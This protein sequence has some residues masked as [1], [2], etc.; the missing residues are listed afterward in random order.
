VRIVQVNLAWDA[1]LREP[2]ALLA[3]YRTLTG[4]SDALTAAGAR[5]H[6]IQRFS[7]DAR[8]IRGNAV[9]DFVRDGP[10]GTPGPW[11]SLTRVVNAVG[12]RAPDVVHINGLMFP[13]AVR[14]IRERVGRACAVVLQ[15]HSGF[16][17]RTSWWPFG[18]G[19]RS[20]WR[21]AFGDADAC[22]FT[23][24]DLAAPWYAVGLAEDTPIVEIPEAST[25]FVA[26]DRRQ[27]RSWTGLQ[28]DPSILW[29]GRL[30]DNKDPLTVLNALE[31][32]LPVLPAAQ[33]LMIVPADADNPLAHRRHEIAS[34]IASSEAL[35]G[36]ISMIGPLAH[37]E[38]P[39]YYSAAD[40]FVSGSRHEGS[41]YSLIEAMACGVS[42]CVTDVPAFRGLTGGCGALWRAGD[43]AACAAALRDLAMRDLEAERQVVREHFERAMSW[44]V[45]GRRT[46]DTYSTLVS[47]RRAA[48]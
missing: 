27:A 17:P 28:G 41:G 40:I 3:S 8:V 29:V 38:M 5:V 36:R 44:H 34:R 33:V 13:G 37:E 32:V 30:D 24:H 26:I 9:Y 1:E 43:A 4:L 47:T 42:P 6:V 18:E 20:A 31:Q 2:E 15:D 12:D 7:S 11:T 16:I 10:P 19:R 23:A 46:L 39:A 22:T 48:R 45:I 14:A 25:H 35:G 21:R